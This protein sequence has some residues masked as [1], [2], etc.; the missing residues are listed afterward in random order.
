MVE[1]HGGMHVYSMSYSNQPKTMFTGDSDREKRGGPD[2]VC[3]AE[4]DFS[5]NDMTRHIYHSTVALLLCHV[6]IFLALF[7]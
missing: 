3:E 2:V 1:K 7:C 5:C 4:N 6:Q